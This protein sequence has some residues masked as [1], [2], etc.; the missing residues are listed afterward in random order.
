MEA[1]INGEQLLNLL[2]ALRPLSKLLAHHMDGAMQNR[3]LATQR[4]GPINALGPCRIPSDDSKRV[5][6]V[7]RHP[8]LQGE[9]CYASTSSLDCT[10][11][12]QQ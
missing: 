7:D 5:G 8:T 10:V 9:H 1:R 2:K 3:C 4:L 11:G 12:V 6:T